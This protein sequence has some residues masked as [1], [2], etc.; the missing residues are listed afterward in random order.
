MLDLMLWYPSYRAIKRG[1]VN[2]LLKC[3]FDACLLVAGVEVV[4][5]CGNG[6]NWHNLVPLQYP[7]WRTARLVFG[8]MAKGGGK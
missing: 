5:L 8:L 1:S 4:A 3:Q 6:R 2:Q 7:R